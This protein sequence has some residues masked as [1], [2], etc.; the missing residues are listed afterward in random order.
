MAKVKVKIK[1]HQDLVLPKYMTEG[2]AGFDL[3]ARGLRKVYKGTKEVNLDLFMYTIEQGYFS[4]RAQERAVIGTGLFIE[5]PVGKELQVRSRSGMSAKRGLVVGNS[6]GTIDSDYR[7]EICVI[8]VNTTGFISRINF[9]DAIAQGV[10]TDYDQVEWDVVKDLTPSGRK[11]GFG[12][13]DFWTPFINTVED[14]VTNILKKDTVF[15]EK[16][17]I[18]GEY[19]VTGGYAIVFP[20]SYTFVGTRPYD[21]RMINKITIRDDKTIINEYVTNH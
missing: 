13:T 19:I 3:I 1:D 18:T 6:P 12:S 10:V 4:L 20:L 11:G 17:I 2:S 9:G 7:E 14:C 5:L 8:L 16:D 21:G 15:T